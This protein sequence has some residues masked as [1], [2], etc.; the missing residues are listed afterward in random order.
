MRPALPR[1]SRLFLLASSLCLLVLLATMTLRVTPLP[2]SDSA[3]SPQS[4]VPA[5]SAASAATA[6]ED[7][8]VRFARARMDASRTVVLTYASYSYK[9]PLMNWLVA[10]ARLRTVRNVGVICLDRELGEYL[11]SLGET[12]LG[13]SEVASA[14]AGAGLD[15]ASVAHLWVVRAEHVSRL[16]RQGISVVVSDSD[17]LWLRDP[18]ASGLFSAGT[19]D[20]V[21]GKGRFPYDQP[22]GAALCMGVVYLRACP[23]VVALAEQALVETRAAE[24]DQIGYNRALARM[25]GESAAAA[26]GR[27]VHPTGTSR[28][29]ARLREDVAGAQQLTLVL[30]EHQ[31]IPRECQVG[32]RVSC[33]VAG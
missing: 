21:G 27:R 7:P 14:R 2:S 4:A 9:V 28:A 33:R 11:A 30:V 10:I 22:W 26:F 24:D 19:G 5:S 6:E 32:S 18:F 16:L 31:V 25:R 13:I 29:T 1:I 23:A 12:C 17:A 3:S 20:V 15:L 8:L